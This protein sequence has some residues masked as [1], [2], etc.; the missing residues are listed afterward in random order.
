MD[1]VKQETRLKVKQ[2]MK[3][4]DYARA[5]QVSPWTIYR[6]VEKDE[7]EFERFGR[8]IRIVVT[9]SGGTNI[10]PKWKEW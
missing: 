5:A 8:A 10:A 6:M 9:S 7:I 2:Y 4:K 3:V 1:S